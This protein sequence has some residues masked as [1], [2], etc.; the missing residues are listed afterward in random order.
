MYS[1]SGNC[2]ASVPIYTSCSTVQLATLYLHE[3]GTIG[4]ALKR[5]ST[6]IGFLIFFISVLNIWNDFKVLSRFIQKWIQT[7]ASSD[8]GLYWILSSN[9]LTH[10]YLMKKSAKGLHYLVWIAGCWNSSVTSRNPQNNCCLS[11][12]SG[13]RYGGKDCGL[14]T[15]KPWSDQAGGLEAFLY[16]AAQNFKGLVARCHSFC[17]FI[18]YDIH[19]FI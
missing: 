1:F 14:C 16:L 19:T 18:F 3:S 4:Y 5:T 10:F 15:Y 8:Y 17:L 13:A 11:R 9:W 12:I 2:A 7:P 6:A